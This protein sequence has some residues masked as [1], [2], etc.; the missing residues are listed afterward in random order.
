MR[1]LTRI[2]ILI[3]YKFILVNLLMMA[4]KSSGQSQFQPATDCF[5]RLLV[6]I[7]RFSLYKLLLESWAL[8]WFHP[9]EW[10]D[11]PGFDVMTSVCIVFW[12][13]CIKVASTLPLQTGGAGAGR[14]VAG[15]GLGQSRGY[16]VETST[17]GLSKIKWYIYW[18]L[19]QSRGY[20]VE[21]SP[22][23]DSAR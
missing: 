5:L 10:H 15:A 20:Y 13:R 3:F 19:E 11:A 17:P 14:R 22:H 21:T 8:M 1:C 16:Y 6:Y 12:S 9:P 7:N 2:T 18:I 23:L 4:L